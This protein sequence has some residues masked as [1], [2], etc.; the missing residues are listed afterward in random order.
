MVTPVAGADDATW[1]HGLRAS[2]GRGVRRVQ[3]RAPAIDPARWRK[4]VAEA[5]ALCRECG[6]EAL[7]NGDAS[8]AREHGLGLH[9]RAAQ[10]RD[11]DPASRVAGH[12]LAASCHDAAD[13]QRA[14]A[15]GCDFVVL[16]TVRPTPSHPGL[17]GIGWEGVAALREDSALPIYAIGGLDRGD[18]ADARTHGAQGIAAI[19]GLW[20]SS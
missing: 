7:L 15:L 20:A 2:I 10:L 19:R 18:I 9:L 6:V 5:A 13:L 12:A 17:P 11:F 14:A 4:L 16:G 8:L 1:L 3:L